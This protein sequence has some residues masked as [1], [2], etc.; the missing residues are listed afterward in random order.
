MRGLLFLLATA[1]SAAEPVAF[2]DIKDFLRAYDGE[3]LAIRGEVFASKTR[4]DLVLSGDCPESR[5]NGSSVFINVEQTNG[6]ARVAWNR[7]LTNFEQAQAGNRPA[8]AVATLHGTLTARG[9]FDRGPGFGRG[10]SLQASLAL[11]S[12]SDPAIEVFP[13][14]E[15]RPVIP[16]CDVLRNPEAVLGQW[17]AVRGVAVGGTWLVDPACV[18][19]GA[20][21]LRHPSQPLGWTEAEFQRFIWILRR[22]SRQPAVHATAAG[23]LRQTELDCSAKAALILEAAFDSRDAS[24]EETPPLPARCEPA[25]E[26]WDSLRPQIV[27]AI[28][29]GDVESLKQLLRRAREAKR[30]GVDLLSAARQQ[31]N[32]LVARLLMA[33]GWIWQP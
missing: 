21:A 5:R 16:V 2:C 6:A 3:T 14:P 25:K 11:A 13:K 1:C 4:A 9:Q 24:P 29:S 12:L 8:H 18:N 19:S 15:E 32:P 17:I 27:Q 23:L 22:T 7:F 30:E 10:G 31:T 20:I 26:S 28:R 33:D